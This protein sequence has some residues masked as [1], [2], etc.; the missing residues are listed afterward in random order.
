M[1]VGLRKQKLGPLPCLSFL[2][3]HSCSL[4][5]VDK[6]LLLSYQALCGTK[7]KKYSKA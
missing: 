1:I 2:T 4:C 6:P 5:N 7:S 3:F